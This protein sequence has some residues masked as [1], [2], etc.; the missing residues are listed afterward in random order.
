MFET[1][2]FLPPLDDGEIARQVDYVIANGWTPCLEFAA[3]EDAYVQD[4]S[5]I[6]FGNA[7]S[8]VRPHFT[9]APLIVCLSSKRTG[10]PSVLLPAH[11]APRSYLPV[12]KRQLPKGFALCAGMRA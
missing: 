10:L 2:S 1:F 4:R 3:P 12:E 9:C 7:A 11:G 6:R 5:Q 8:C